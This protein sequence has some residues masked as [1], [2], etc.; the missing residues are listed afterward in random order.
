MKKNGEGEA[1][2]PI[3][4]GVSTCLLGGK[5]RYDGGHKHD[6]YLTDTLGAF[7]EWVAVCPE[8]ECGMSIPREAIHLVRKENGV[9]LVGA[10]SGED[11][12]DRMSKYVDRRVSQLAGEGLCGY[13][14][15]KDS[16]SCG[17]E[18]VRLHEGPGQVSR[19]G[20]GLFAAV[21]AERFPNLPVE[22]E[23]RLCDSR[24]RENWIERVFAY[25]RLKSLWAG[26]WGIRA[27]AEFHAAHKLTLMAHS[28]D[29]LREL[30]RLVATAKSRKKAELRELYERQ[31]MA[32]LK[33][34]ATPGRHANVL[35]HMFG[36]FSKELDDASR[37]EMLGCIDD[38]R[39]GLLPLIVPVT[40]V[41]H[42][43]RVFDVP[44]LKGQVYLNP[45]PK[46]LALRNHV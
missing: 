15:K 25:H 40:L 32:A 2:V 14:L 31:F 8:V 33:C 4:I 9:R 1:E 29:G 20:R 44:Y 46:E 37:K 3:R 11:H 27:L 30:G 38:Y 45:H 22:E 12:T 24:L 6:R 26:S 18:R 21:L 17:L 19:S 10:R 28:P 5:V 36:Y 41:S 43:V 34:M 39:R 42:Y 16:P 7:F 13:I 23:G 35:Q